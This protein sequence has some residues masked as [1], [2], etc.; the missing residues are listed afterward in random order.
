[1]G[2]P[3]LDL[4][5]PTPRYIPGRWGNPE[6]LDNYESEDLE[7]NILDVHRKGTDVSLGAGPPSIA[8]IYA[9]S[10]VFPIDPVSGI[11][12]RPAK[13]CCGQR[14]TPSI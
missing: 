5:G 13:S 1:L 2:Q 12:K 8:Y 14:T 6:N 4:V 10:L 11:R 9:T 3:G 7:E